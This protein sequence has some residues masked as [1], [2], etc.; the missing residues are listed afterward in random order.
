MQNKVAF[1]QKTL[2]K[3]STLNVPALKAFRF[4]N[5]AIKHLDCVDPLDSVEAP[6]HYEETSYPHLSCD[7][8]ASHLPW[9][10]HSSP[11][12]PGNRK[13]NQCISLNSNNYYYLLKTSAYA[14]LTLY[15]VHR[16]HAILRVITLSLALHAVRCIGCSRS[17]TGSHHTV[18]RARWGVGS[19]AGAQDGPWG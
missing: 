1:I 17:R 18:D 3:Q 15:L 10:C 12:W 4:K 2:I 14:V 7:Q 16:I 5:K 11:P 6:Y 13:K 9:S 19:R 8:N